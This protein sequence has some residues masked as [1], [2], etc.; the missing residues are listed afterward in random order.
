MKRKGRRQGY[1][2]PNL[3]SKQKAITAVDPSSAVRECELV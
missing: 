3:F 2:D 1:L